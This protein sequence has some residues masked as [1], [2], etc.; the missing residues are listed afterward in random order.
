MPPLSLRIDARG[1]AT[2]PAAGYN[3][4]VSRGWESKS[5]EE[6]QAQFASRKLGARPSLTPLEAAKQQKKQ[7]L[8][9]SRHRVVQQ[10]E[11]AQN[12]QH[13][14]LLERALADL[15]SKLAQLC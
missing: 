8:E 7:G 5:V 10:L 2:V 3:F 6:Q 12:P 11:S 4:P 15:D 14:E 9:L 13:R 1:P